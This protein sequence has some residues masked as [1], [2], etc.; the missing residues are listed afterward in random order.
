MPIRQFL[1]QTP[2]FGPE[3]FKIL[4][5]VFE[6]ALARLGLI[7]LNDPA[8]TIVAKRIIAVA[9]RG[10][11]DPVRLREAALNYKETP[12][13][14]EQ[15]VPCAARTKW[16]KCPNMVLSVLSPEAM[17]LL[18][19]HFREK[20]CDEGDVLWNAGEYL[21]EVYFPLSGMISVCVPTKNGCEAEVAVIGREG[22]A[23][24]HDRLGEGL[25]VF[26]Q[27]R[28][29]VGGRFACVTWR[30]FAAAAR[31]SE[32]LLDVVAVC[33]EWVLLQAQQMAACNAV[34][35][36]PARVSRWLLRVADTLGLEKLPAT[37]ESIANALGIR[38][39]TA[40]LIAQEL[41]R[42]KAISYTRG[43]IVIVDRNKLEAAACDCYRVLCKSQWA[44]EL[45]RSCRT[46]LTSSGPSALAGQILGTSRTEAQ[47]Q[48]HP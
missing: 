43:Q 6:D 38:R 36:A 26:T 17:S 45:L 29:L 19:T 22:A 32:E 28:V 1:K 12:S 37:Q 44:S 7:N 25:P 34:H 14:A 23:G 2:A 27:A 3:D 10:E 47:G 40:T 16:V 11:R 48:L 8:T 46:G 42:K 30:A 13:V 39:T 20:N 5:A 33:K 24:V 21:R 41:Q 4:A 9:S 35:G 15:R 31:E 18:H